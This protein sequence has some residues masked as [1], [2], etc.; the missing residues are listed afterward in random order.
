MKSHYKG[1]DIDWAPVR[2]EL[3]LT[4]EL[5]AELGVW[6]VAGSNHRLTGDH[7]PHNSTYVISDQGKL[8]GRYDK[9][10]LSSTEVHG[11]YTPGTQPMVF[12]VDDTTFGI[13]TCI[14]VN[15]PE[16]WV[17]YAQLGVDCVLFGSYSED[18][19]F[20]TILLGHAAATNMWIS[21]SVPAACSTAMPAGIIGPHGSWLAECT[22]DGR[23]GLAAADL[24]PGDPQLKIA[25][26]AARPWRATARHGDIYRRGWSTTRAS[27]TAPPSD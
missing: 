19:V 8:V 25:L 12:T 9:R 4:A 21:V 10:L 16:L 17:E 5:A 3:E 26:H 14:E 1:W 15:F 23:P 6:I 13:L 2:R 27:S 20:E 24:D 11:F 7:W 22:R 18:P